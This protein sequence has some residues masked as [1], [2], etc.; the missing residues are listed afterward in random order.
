MPLRPETSRLLADLQI[1]SGSRLTKVDDLGT[2]L[3]LGR[4]SG[5]AQALDELIFLA[6]FLT[7]VH[8]IMQRIGPD[9]TGYSKLLTEFNDKL[10][11]SAGLLRDLLAAAPGD[12]RNHFILT[13]LAKTQEGLRNYL[14]LLYDLSWYKNWKL[15]HQ[16][17]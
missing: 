10:E 17:E 2:L 15:D 14:A 4:D 8:G 9:V 12:V 3:E 13:Y 16:R 11:E 1:F 6:K 7:R 5:S